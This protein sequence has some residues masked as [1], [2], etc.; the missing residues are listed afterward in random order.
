MPGAKHSK[1]TTFVLFKGKLSWQ[2]HL[3]LCQLCIKSHKHP[4]R[5]LHVYDRCHGCGR[6]K[7][8]QCTPLEIECY[9]PVCLVPCQRGSL[10]VFLSKS[11]SSFALE[12]TLEVLFFSN[13]LIK[14]C[15]SLRVTISPKQWQIVTSFVRNNLTFG[16]LYMQS[17]K[18]KKNTCWQHHR[19][20]LLSSVRWSMRQD[21]KIF[22]SSP[23][24]KP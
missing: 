9:H 11:P 5:L 24:P 15:R 10:Q 6:V 3:K 20:F 12:G 8:I 13:R 2:R 1:K 18:I 16:W 23:L 17:R 22:W 21:F 4:Q 19:A 7:S 14:G